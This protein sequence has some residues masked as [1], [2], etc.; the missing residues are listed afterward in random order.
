MLPDTSELFWSLDLLS[1]ASARFLLS[2]L[3]LLQSYNLLFFPNPQ[4]LSFTYSTSASGLKIRPLLQLCLI[5][6]GE[7]ACSVPCGKNCSTPEAHAI[8]C[9]EAWAMGRILPSA[10]LLPCRH[11]LCLRGSDGSM[12]FLATCP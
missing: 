12:H 2:Y 9:S 10:S 6:S 1:C 11:L 8:P 7:S 5:L 3:L 4:H